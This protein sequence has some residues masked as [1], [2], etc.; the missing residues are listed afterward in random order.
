MKNEG[1][2]SAGVLL[3]FALVFNGCASYE[4]VADQN[5]EISKIYDIELSKDEIF[6]G[7]LQFIAEN[8]TSAKSVIEYQDR[9]AGR[10]IGN[11]ST[12]V[13][14]GLMDRDA[15]FTMVIDIKDNR[16]RVSF[17]SLQYKAGTAIPWGPIEYKTPYDDIAAQLNSLADRLR[18]YLSSSRDNQNF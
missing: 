6:D 12:K 14:D 7:S 3:A 9:D 17:R 4:K 16:Y 10:I 2:V 13:S 11:G 1:F 5:S 15:T 8:F 18:T